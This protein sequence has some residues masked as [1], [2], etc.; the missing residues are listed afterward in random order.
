M[1]SIFDL[2]AADIEGDSNHLRS[3]LAQEISE[4]INLEYKADDTSDRVLQSVAAMANTYGGVIVL[5]VRAA[6]DRPGEVVGVDATRREA[7]VNQCHAKLTP[8]IHPEV[9]PVDIESKRVLVVRIDVGLVLRPVVLDGKVWVR[10]SG[11][12][13][14]ADL[15]RM[16]ALF[17]ETPISSS[18]VSPH[19][20]TMPPSTFHRPTSQGERSLIVRSGLEVV[21]PPTEW[22]ILIETATT[23][24]LVESLKKAP[25]STWLV[26]QMGRWGLHDLV[27]WA[28]RTRATSNHVTL[29]WR[30]LM[31][32]GG[33]AVLIGQCVLTI[34]DQLLTTGGVATLLLD[35]VLLP[36]VLAEAHSAAAGRSIPVN[37]LSLSEL[38]ELLDVLVLST[39]LR[40]P[41]R[42][43]PELIELPVWQQAGPAV[44]ID[45]YDRPM[46]EL[47]D[48]GTS[49]RWPEANHGYGAQ[50]P[51]RGGVDLGER[52][53]RRKLIATWLTKMLLDESCFGFEQMLEGL[54]ESP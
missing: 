7:L 43:V 44:Y 8:P 31:P 50:F 40:L 36:D 1:P 51:M 29:S 27:D 19:M 34:P 38:F 5:G 23:E 39:G 2:P 33:A 41:E 26:R 47:I 16:R 53:T 10:G 49:G 3:F 17:A 18:L 22:P 13:A 25:V 30:A 6:G 9:I 28:V 45:A 21:L 48:Y 11:R 14:A 46:D 42:V 52:T 15:F 37:R 32:G 24:R 54:I 12:N 4:G 35:V 20:L